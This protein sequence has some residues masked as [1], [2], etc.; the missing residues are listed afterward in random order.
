M[1]V[2]SEEPEA[3]FMKFLTPLKSVGKLYK[4]HTAHTRI[5]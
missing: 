4:N 5:E 1:A 2:Q 3:S